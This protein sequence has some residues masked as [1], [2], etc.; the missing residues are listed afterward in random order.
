[1][2]SRFYSTL[3]VCA[4]MGA[5]PVTV[6]GQQ[7]P[8]PK[9]DLRHLLPPPTAP[10]NPTS[11]TAPVPQ[12]ATPT[13]PPLKPAPTT[14]LV[15]T[16][17]TPQE[18]EMRRRLQYR[19]RRAAL[20]HVARLKQYPGI[21]FAT[22]SRAYHAKK[23]ALQEVLT[24]R[25]LRE[26]KIA[27]A[28]RRALA[29]VKALAS[30]ARER[31]EA[32]QRA[33]AVAMRKVNETDPGQPEAALAQA[34]KTAEQQP[35]E[36]ITDTETLPL[37]SKTV[38]L[39][40]VDPLRRSEARPLTLP[41]KIHTPIPAE[42]APTEPT[43]TFPGLRSHTPQTL[44]ESAE[45]EALAAYKKEQALK[46]IREEQEKAEAEE[47]AAATPN[48]VTKAK[49]SELIDLYV[50]GEIDRDEYHR[51]RAKVLGIRLKEDEE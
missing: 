47:R 26:E 23:N 9:I 31:F 38:N 49:I 29:E 43:S 16:A 27:F 39:S 36:T 11:P 1:M 2:N 12:P 50:K 18:L 37:I 3:V 46:R 22:I 14:P 4:G 25:K 41:G 15:Q 40:Y 19:Q 51:R 48:E 45:I 6:W 20:M 7:K 34:A 32:E 35:G 42:G 33:L 5:A 13:E 10:A 17:P 24:D 30:A 21:S 28:K 44:K 8:P